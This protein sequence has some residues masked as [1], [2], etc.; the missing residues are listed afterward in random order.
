MISPSIYRIS[1]V[2]PVWHSDAPFPVSLLP[3]APTM[4]AWPAPAADIYIR[5]DIIKYITLGANTLDRNLAFYQGFI[6]VFTMPK[7]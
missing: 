1:A 6:R 5:P 4:S 7:V 3:A 2:G